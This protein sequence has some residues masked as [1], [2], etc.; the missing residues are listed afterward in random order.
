MR[1]YRNGLKK[2]RRRRS[3]FTSEKEDRFGTPIEHEQDWPLANPFNFLE[4]CGSPPDSRRPYLKA[5]L[6]SFGKVSE[7]T[8]ESDGE[9]QRTMQELESYKIWIISGVTEVRISPGK[10]D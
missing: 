7:N 9:L 5:A 3:Q 1:L 10:G 6:T 4:P 2:L 8:R